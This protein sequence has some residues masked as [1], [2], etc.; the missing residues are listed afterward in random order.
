M[1]G[2]EFGGVFVQAERVSRQVRLAW[3][4]RAIIAGFSGATAMLF[5]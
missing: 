2:A 5:A 3:L 4:P 1:A